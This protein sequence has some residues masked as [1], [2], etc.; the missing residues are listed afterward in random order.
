MKKGS[1][2]VFLG[3]LISMIMS[4][5]FSMGEVTR[6]LSLYQEG[7]SLAYT[8]VQSAFGE[9]NR[10]LWKDYGILAIDGKYGGSEE[11]YALNDAVSFYIEENYGDDDGVDFLQLAPEKVEMKEIV[12]MTDSDGAAFVK[13][14][15]KCVEA[16]MTKDGWSALVD[17]CSSCSSTSDQTMDIKEILNNTTDALNYKESEKTEED[18]G[19]A[20]E[21]TEIEVSDESKSFIATVLE[22][23]NK[24]ILSQIFSDTSSISDAAFSTDELVST[25]ELNVGKTEKIEVSSLERMLYQ[26]YLTTHFSCYGSEQ[27]EDGMK[28]ELEYILCGKNSDLENLAST[29]ERLLAVREVQ[30]LVSLSM[31]EVKVAEAKALAASASAVLLSPELEPVISYGIMAAWAYMESVLDVR[32][33]LGGGKV[34]LLKSPEEW[35]SSLQNI[36]ACLDTE[37]K[38]KECAGGISYKQYLFAIYILESQQ[39]IT[40]RGLDLVEEALRQSEDYQNVSMDHFIVSAEAEVVLRGNPLFLCFIPLYTQSI[41]GYEFQYTQSMSYF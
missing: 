7:K 28:Y 22:F 24:A 12:Y 14:A 19:E 36:G 34:A 13:E 21:K 8:G 4:L 3:L 5:F 33:L 17:A 38:A 32:L 11:G 16:E 41:D 20:E 6:Y 39:T 37:T 1:M 30:N 10:P 18:S 25:R 31:D 40:Y 23:Q 27:H 9:Y 35:T 15:A 29:V 26:Y 2:S